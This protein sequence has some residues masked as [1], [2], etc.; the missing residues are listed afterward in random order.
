MF[1]E[2]DLFHVVCTG[3]QLRLTGYWFSINKFPLG[4]LIN[5][6][7]CNRCIV[8]LVLSQC[9]KYLYSLSCRIFCYFVYTFHLI[10]ATKILLSKNRIVPVIPKSDF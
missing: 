10:V 5:E 3:I 8:L 6:T 1:K 2:R 7:A 4:T 9:L